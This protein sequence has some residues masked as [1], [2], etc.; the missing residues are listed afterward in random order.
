MVNT[1]PRMHRLMQCN[2]AS[3]LAPLFYSRQALV[4]C[5]TCR[6][7]TWLS[8]SREACLAAEGADCARAF[9]LLHALGCD[10]RC[11]YAF[12]CILCMMH[13][14]TY[15]HKHTHTRTHTH[16]YAC[17]WVARTHARFYLGTWCWSCM[18]DLHVP[19]LQS[20]VT[21]SHT[22]PHD[23]CILELLYAVLGTAALCHI[24]PH[25][26]NCSKCG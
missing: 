11:M 18:T 25:A 15:T 23:V 3:V 10:I 14:H 7:R 9:M 5:R 21:N 26:N 17:M 12:M 4:T 24:S 8:T 13:T 2:Q 22:E 1:C 6:A 16:T 19:N 20:R